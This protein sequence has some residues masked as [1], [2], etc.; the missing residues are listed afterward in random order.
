M[1]NIKI[2]EDLVNHG[3][4][5]KDLAEMRK[6]LN[7]YNIT[8]PALIKAL[9]SQFIVIMSII[10]FFIAVWVYVIVCEDESS[11]ISYSITMIIVIP[12]IYIFGALKLS[13]K[14]FKYKRLH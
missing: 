7:E 1:N 2:E 6:R 11:V 10:V 14:A 13:F 4:T 9:H 3:F 8:Y 5:G 12:I